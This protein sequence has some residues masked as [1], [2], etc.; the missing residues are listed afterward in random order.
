MII[1]FLLFL[2]LFR[3]YI[4]GENL[5]ISIC[6]IS[7]FLAG[8]LLVN[9]TYPNFPIISLIFWSTLLT[10]QINTKTKFN[11][12]DFNSYKSIKLPTHKKEKY[13]LFLSIISLSHI[14]FINP[15][16]IIFLLHLGLISTLYNVP[17]K[18]KSKSYFPL[19]SVPMLKIFLIAYVW[20]SISSFLPAILANE[21]VFTSQIIFVFIAHLLFIISIALQFDIRDFQD[22]NKKALITFPQLLG[23]IPAK[24][25][26]IVCL[27]V[28]TLIINHI[29]KEWLIYAFSM[30]TAVLILNSSAEKKDYYFTFYLD[31]TIILYFITI[32]LS[33]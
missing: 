22:D 20:A 31:G 4:L 9:G 15:G 1:S 30:V 2:K 13:I 23:I 18:S 12:F 16:S 26:A 27:F 21:K 5:F 29:T 8:S 10:Y 25:L 33:L 24:L 19:R 28:F 6:S 32:I 11:F 14:P 3:Q 7:F 17:E